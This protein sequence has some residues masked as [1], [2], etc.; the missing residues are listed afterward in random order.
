MRRLNHDVP[1]IGKMY[2]LHMVERCS[3]WLFLSLKTAIVQSIV[4]TTLFIRTLICHSFIRDLLN[5]FTRVHLKRW[6]VV[7]T[8]CNRNMLTPSAVSLT[9]T[10]RTTENGEDVHT[11]PHFSLKHV[12]CPG[13][14]QHLY[15]KQIFW[16][17][18]AHALLIGAWK[19][20][21]GRGPGNIDAFRCWDCRES[22]N[23]VQEETRGSVARTI[24]VLLLFEFD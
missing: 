2:V 3:P 11:A 8:G 16:E 1:S 24:S 15:L 9:R 12:D 23:K 17:R 7:G 5:G 6:H 4:H 20:Y 21:R 22:W 14:L 19:R 10:G 13:Q 18:S